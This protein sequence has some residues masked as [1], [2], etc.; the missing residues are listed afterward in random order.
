[1]FMTSAK[2]WD[3]IRILGTCRCPK[4]D[5]TL[6]WP[7]PWWSY[8][9]MSLS[10]RLKELI[11]T[12]ST[13]GEDWPP[14]LYTPPSQKHSKVK[15]LTRIDLNT[16]QHLG[17]L[18]SDSL[19]KLAAVIWHAFHVAGPPSTLDNLSEDKL[20]ESGL[21]FD[22]VCVNCIKRRWRVSKGEW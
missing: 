21:E 2:T 1:M 9:D 3:R 7:C 19:W 5:P 16:L 22:G 13:L 15:K 18:L 12:S 8:L 4:D 14:V 6:I 17:R 10:R 11:R 20:E